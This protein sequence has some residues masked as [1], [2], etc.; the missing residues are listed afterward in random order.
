MDSY[1][2]RQEES[3]SL[4][5]Y[6]YGNA[7]PV[8]QIDPSGY[9]S[10]SAAEIGK[11]VHK[12]I[13]EDFKRYA[14]SSASGSAVSTILSAGSGGSFSAV[15]NLFP[16]LVD[17]GRH[18]IYEIKPNSVANFILGEAQLE[19][20]LQVLQHFD[21]ASR[22]HRGQDYRAPLRID[23]GIPLKQVVTQPTVAGIILYSVIDI[24]DL[25]KNAVK[26][27]IKAKQAQLDTAF[28]AATLTSMLG[29]F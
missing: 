1:E 7:D 3:L 13:A 12:A 11:K 14:R 5:K 15:V 21:P 10:T 16:D 28:Q 8:N 9:S 18:E 4:H 20:Y 6:L 17:S 2:G 25:I 27:D 24:R 19:G 22:W 29:G 26:N 23:I